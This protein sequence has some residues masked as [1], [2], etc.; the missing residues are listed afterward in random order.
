MMRIEQFYSIFRFIASKQLN[1]LKRKNSSSWKNE[2]KEF[3]LKNIIGS[4]Y[5]KKQ[6][7]EFRKKQKEKGRRK[8]WKAR[9]ERLDFMLCWVFLGAV[10]E[11]YF[12]MV[13][14]KKGWIWRNHHVTRTR[15]NFIGSKFN[16]D[17]S[18]KNFLNDKASFCKC[19]DSYLHRKWCVPE[20]ISIEEFEEKFKD[21]STLLAKRRVGYG[22][23]GVMVFDTSEMEFQEIYD[24]VLSQNESYIVEEYHNQSG[25]LHE[26]NP[27][28]L[29]TIRVSTLSINGKTD[30]IFAYLRVGVKGAV[31]DNLHSGGIRFPIDH[32]TG[33][34][35]KG[36]NY[37]IFDVETH[38]DSGIQVF[39]KTIPRWDEIVEFCKKAHE[40]APE[41]LHWVGWDVCLDEEDMSLI[42]GNS[43]PG[44]P[45][46]ENP[47]ENWWKDMKYYLSQLEKS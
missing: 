14:N 8:G 30:V 16:P 35:F 45:P 9:F 44:F 41:D 18:S 21:V 17:I 46:I 34:I 26:I 15:M 1:L 29:N 28:S 38:P 25:W 31:V 12:S 11:D 4:S 7:P 33:K 36:M 47:H 5:E 10:P 20:E 42:E 27:S 23:K 37:Q 2:W 43:G 40:L 19:W 22:G 24:T 6:A 3:H 13:F 32:R 39:D